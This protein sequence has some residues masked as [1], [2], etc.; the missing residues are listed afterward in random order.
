M[1]S[2]EFNIHITFLFSTTAHLWRYV[3]L[4]ERHDIRPLLVFDGKELPLKYE[5]NERRNKYILMLFINNLSLKKHVMQKLDFFLSQTDNTKPSL[6][7]HLQCPHQCISQHKTVWFVQAYPW[8]V[9][10]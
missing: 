10:Q 6:V 8:F 3:R 5:E 9:S 2:L 7:H 4:L 1:S